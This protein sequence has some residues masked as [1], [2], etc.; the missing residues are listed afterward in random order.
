MT[1]VAAVIRKQLLDHAGNCDC[2]SDAWLERELVRAYEY[3][4][5]A[6]GEA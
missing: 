1:L 5:N 2:G 4:E 6:K 3:K